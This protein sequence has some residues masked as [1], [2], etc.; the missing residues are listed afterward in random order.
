MKRFSELK[1]I[2]R[3]DPD[4]EYF[5]PKKTEYNSIFEAEK[6]SKTTI[7]TFFSKIF[8]S[9]EVAHVFHLQV[10]G[11]MGSSAKHVA[12][13]AYYEGILEPLD[14]LIEIYQGQFGK[15]LQGYDIIDTT[16]NAKTDTI[17]YFTDLADFI[18]K[19]RYK[20]FDRDDTH[21]FNIIDDILVMIYKLLYKLK[22]TK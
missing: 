5:K 12:L 9:K 19:E 1:T 18:K 2:K 20:C 15:I 8:E 6:K 11:D 4:K 14:D 16:K 22:F 7:I 13:Q 17:E 3:V 21:Y 10:K